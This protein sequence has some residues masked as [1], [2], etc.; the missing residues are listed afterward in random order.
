MQHRPLQPENQTHGFQ[1]AFFAFSGSLKQFFLRFNFRKRILQPFHQ[2]AHFCGSRFAKRCQSVF[3]ARWHGRIRM[4]NNH[5]ILFQILQSLREHS[6]AD[7]INGTAQFAESFR[8]V[9]Q[10]NQDQ[11]TPTARQMLQ[12]QARWTTCR[13]N[14]AF[15]KNNFVIIHHV[16]SKINTYLFVSIYQK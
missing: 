7:T 9:F 10:Y 11:H 16:I 1:A 13:Q 12:N 8:S 2:I 4:A 3:H 5:A 14:I 15:F 6:F